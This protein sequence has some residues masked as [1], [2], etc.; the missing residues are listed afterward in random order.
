MKLTFYGNQENSDIIFAT[1]DDVELTNSDLS[2]STMYDNRLSV[3]H[4][5]SF[6]GQNVVRTGSYR[7]TE[8]DK[9]IFTPNNQNICSFVF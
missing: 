8:Y 6:Q 5:Y 2:I 4:R 9:S 7:S 1:L 3:Y